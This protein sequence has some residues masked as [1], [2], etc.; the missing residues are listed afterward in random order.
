MDKGAWRL[1]AFSEGKLA[2]ATAWPTR[3]LFSS[4]K[5][6]L[7]RIREFGIVPPEHFARPFEKDATAPSRRHP[8]EDEDMLDVVKSRIKRQHM[9]KTGPN[10]PD[11]TQVPQLE[12]PFY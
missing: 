6:E 5:V 10:Q 9:A 4:G 7:H 3:R 12:R 1:Q 11:L 2:A 8:T